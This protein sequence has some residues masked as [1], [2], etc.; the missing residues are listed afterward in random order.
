[1]STTFHQGEQFIQSESGV[2]E[3]TQKLGNKLIRDHIIDQHKEFFEGLPYAF[4]ALHD[5]QGQPWATMVTGTAGFINSPNSKTLTVNGAVIGTDVLGVNMSNNKPI[6]LVGLDFS[7]RRRNR[8]NG[9]IGSANRGDGFSIKVEQSFGNCPKYIQQRLYQPNI[10]NKTRQISKPV[11]IEEIDQFSDRDAYFLSRADTLFIASAE[12][13]N[14]SL[15]VNH[16]GGSA[17]FI[18][19]VGSNKLWFN[20]YPGNNYFQTFGNIHNYPNVGLMFLDFD[21]GD[22]LLL[23][24]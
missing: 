22:L 9:R 3:R 1:M 8:L 5:E 16:R 7:N 20:D 12:S 10:D 2:S 15:D 17:G 18:N 24:G 14:G 23:S 13:A 19:V 4:I 11:S 21:S 6:G